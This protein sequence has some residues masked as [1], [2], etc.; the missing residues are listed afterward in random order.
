MI[1]VF[2]VPNALCALQCLSYGFDHLYLSGGQLHAFEHGLPD[3]NILSQDEV[4]QSA[5]KIGRCRPTEFWVDIDAGECSNLKLKHFLDKLRHAFVTGVQIEDQPL[6]KRCG[7]RSGKQVIS[8]EMMVRRIVTIKEY[9]PELKVIA[10]TDALSLEDADHLKR[11][12]KLYEEAGADILFIEALESAEQLKYIKEYVHKALLVN[13]TEFGKTPYLSDHYWAEAKYHLLPISLA[14]MMHQ[15][16]EKALERLSTS[17][18]Q[19]SLQDKMLTRQRLYS[20]IEYEEK[21]S[22]YN[23]LG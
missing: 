8:A 15:T 13:R 1:K 23:S 5:L 7:H 19:E 11:R 17:D 10:R 20:L 21:E 3:L 12:L 14:R 18:C 4:L 16:V 9:A 22:M 6:H 2:G